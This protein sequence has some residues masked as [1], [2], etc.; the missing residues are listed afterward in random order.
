MQKSVLWNLWL[1]LQLPCLHWSNLANEEV[2]APYIVLKT[3][4]V[5]GSLLY[6]DINI[7]SSAL[8][9]LNGSV[10]LQSLVSENTNFAFWI[11]F[12]VL[13]LTF[14]IS[15]LI[16]QNHKVYLTFAVFNDQQLHLQNG[17]SF[18]TF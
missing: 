16:C 9:N 14:C 17:I 7:F 11:L 2:C 8:E 6:V 3:A 4:A 1:E 15:L 10:G 5:E 12:S 18:Y 13:L